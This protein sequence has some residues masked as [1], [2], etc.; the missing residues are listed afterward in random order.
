MPVSMTR[1]PRTLGLIFDS[2]LVVCHHFLSCALKYN[3]H[4]PCII[5]YSKVF[6]LVNSAFHFV[7]F[8]KYL[9]LIK[10]PPSSINNYHLILCIHHLG[11]LA[12]MDNTTRSATHP[13]PSFKMYLLTIFTILM[14]SICCQALPADGDNG[15][16]YGVWLGG[17]ETADIY[18]V[19]T[20]HIQLLPLRLI[21]Y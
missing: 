17:A 15:R 7:V 12:D 10:S 13:P 14:L 9:L 5:L 19:S 11:S 6:C 3:P 4:S 20:R 1:S 21:Q 8:H 16:I 2:S 18:R